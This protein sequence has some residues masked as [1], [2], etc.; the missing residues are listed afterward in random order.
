MSRIELDHNKKCNDSGKFCVNNGTDICH[1][2]QV[3][4]GDEG[5]PLLYASKR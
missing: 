4:T 1:G 2:C 3:Y 5:K